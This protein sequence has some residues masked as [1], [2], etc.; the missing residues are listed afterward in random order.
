MSGGTTT[1]INATL[2]GIIETAQSSAAFERIL[3][4]APGIIGILNEQIFDVTDL[5]A[6]DL[7]RLRFTLQPFGHDVFPLQRSRYARSCGTDNQIRCDLRTSRCTPDR[8][9]R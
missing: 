3:V 6:A 4:G 5:S 1:V 9:V 7:L 8:R 2:A